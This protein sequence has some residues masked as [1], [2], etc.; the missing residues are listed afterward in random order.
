MK[1]IKR[2]LAAIAISAAA[3]AGCQEIQIENDYT[4]K[5]YYASMEEFQPDTKTYLGEGNQILWDVNDQIL[6]F[7]GGEYGKYYEVSRASVGKSYAEF[8]LVDN[9]GPVNE[10]DKLV[11]FYSIW[12]SYYDALYFISSFSPFFSD[13]HSL[14]SFPMI[15][16]GSIGSKQLAFKNIGG[17]LKLSIKGDRSIESIE[18]SGNSGENLCGFVNIEVGNDGIPHTTSAENSYDHGVYTKTYDGY[19]P[20]ML[21]KEKATDFYFPIIPTDF[22]TGFTVTITDTE[23]NEFIKETNKRNEVKRSHILTMPEFSIESTDNDDNDGE[24][25]DGEEE[26]GNTSGGVQWTPTPGQWIDLGLSVKWAAWD[27]GADSPDEYGGLYAW[28]ETREKVRYDLDTYIHAKRVYFG[29]GED[30]WYLSPTFIGEEISGTE[31]DV[32]HVLWG[33]GARLPTLDEIQ[34]LASKCTFEKGSFKGTEGIFIIGPNNNNIFFPLRICRGMYGEYI[35]YDYYWT[36]TYCE[37][38]DIWGHPDSAH[39]LALDQE[40]GVATDRH[41]GCRFDGLRVRPVKD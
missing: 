25:D 14:E 3:L 40:D 12:D 38:G 22:K 27:I 33:D 24:G 11:A 36:G 29:S 10:Y 34:E 4:P 2:S 13:H 35:Y 15:A 21:S 9:N 20:I 26:E 28:G 37:D 41:G 7:D 18:I 23:G 31:Y 16:V 17:I 19:G 5:K 30:D 8:E 39:S 32:A 6:V 1:T